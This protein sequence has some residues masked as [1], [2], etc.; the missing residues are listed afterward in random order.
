MLH[1]VLPDC[2]WSL[3]TSQQLNKTP[4][5]PYLQAKVLFCSH[6]SSNSWQG[7]SENLLMCSM[8]RPMSSWLP[9]TSVAPLMMFRFS[10][11]CCSRRLRVSHDD[12]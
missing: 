3:L 5:T 7:D 11:S 2:Q 8:A 1:P 4:Y 12:P 9:T 10:S 6:Q